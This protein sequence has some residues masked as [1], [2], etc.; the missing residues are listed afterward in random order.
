MQPRIYTLRWRLPAE[1]SCE[2]APTCHNA[3]PVRSVQFE[4]PIGN[5]TS[6]SVSF[7]RGLEASYNLFN[8]PILDSTVHATEMPVS[9]WQVLVRRTHAEYYHELFTSARTETGKRHCKF[10][11][12]R[13]CRLRG[14]GC[15]LLKL[16]GGRDREPTRTED[17]CVTWT[18]Y[19]HGPPDAA[20]HLR[21]LSALSLM[22]LSR[23]TSSFTYST[24]PAVVLKYGALFRLNAV[25][26][27]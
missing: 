19:R 23:G 13:L 4:C 14:A 18:E 6:L 7:A 26:W 24:T 9:T 5:G 3:R 20:G 22:I 12:W 17:E 27:K 21:R 16:L 11:L 25:S 8:S 1:V 15:S 2:V 10:P